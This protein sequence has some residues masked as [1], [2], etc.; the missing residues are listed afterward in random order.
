M[1]SYNAVAGQ[2]R[3]Y[4]RR[5]VVEL[6]S[7]ACPGG[8]RLHALPMRAWSCSPDDG[9]VKSEPSAR[10]AFCT[11]GFG[12]NAASTGQWNAP[13][14]ILCRALSGAA[15]SGKTQ[16]AVVLGCAPVAVFKSRIPAIFLCNSLHKK[17]ALRKNLGVVFT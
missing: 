7:A 4:E 12:G 1:R 17:T 11:P 14:M 16:G 8:F 5:R 6:I 9:T 10:A 15:N 13:L 2:S 3:V